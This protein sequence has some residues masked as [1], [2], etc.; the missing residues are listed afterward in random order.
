MR[1]KQSGE[2]TEKEK[3]HVKSQVSH[4]FMFNTDTAMNRER[5]GHKNE[6]NQ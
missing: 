3:Q 6:V 5:D 1:A 4:A 2:W